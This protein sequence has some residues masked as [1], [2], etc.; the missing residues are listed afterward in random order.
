MHPAPRAQ[1]RALF[2]PALSIPKFINACNMLNFSIAKGKGGGVCAFQRAARLMHRNFF[3]RRRA[4]LCPAFFWRYK[5]KREKDK[6]N[7][8]LK[9]IENRLSCKKSPAIIFGWIAG[10]AIIIAVSFIA[11]DTDNQTNI[12]P[13]NAIVD[14]EAQQKQEETQKQQEDT[15]EFYKVTWVVDGDTIYVEMNGKTEKIRLIGMN[16]PEIDSRYG[17]G[18]CLGA[19]AAEKAQEILLNKKVLLEA[20]PSQDDRDTYGRLLRYVRLEDGLFFNKWMIENGFAHEYTFIVPYK[21]Q[22]EFKQAQ[23]SARENKLGLWNPNSCS[24]MRL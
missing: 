18:E 23:N 4:F 11:S 3:T 8:M 7:T 19:K 13:S 10:M 22:S 20:D 24:N 5:R 2:D 14:D 15:E 16:A 9:N 1:K 6:M 12:R 17:S 21:Y